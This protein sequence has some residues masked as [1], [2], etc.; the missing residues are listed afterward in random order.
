MEIEPGI[1]QLKIPIPDNPLGYLN[2]YLV[3]GTTGWLMV[4]TG[5]NT[6][7]A[8]NALVEGLKGIG[9]TL[10]DIST[11]LNIPVIAASQLSR[12]IEHR[13]E[14]EQNPTLADLRDSGSIEQDADVVFLLHRYMGNSPVYDGANKDPRI[15]RVK[16]A[17]NRQ[18]GSASAQK[19]FW[20]SDEHQYVN[21]QPVE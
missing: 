14:K 1:Y 17:K 2:C 13:P 16:M 19:L 9:L 6:A 5:W 18:L 3:E 20:K 15:L 12:E 10:K 21:Y 11:D 8:F 4:D 7:E